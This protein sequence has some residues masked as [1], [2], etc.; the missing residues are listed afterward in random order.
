L[1]LNPVSKIQEAQADTPFSLSLAYFIST[2]KVCFQTI[3]ATQ[4]K[5][6]S[7]QNKTKQIPPNQIISVYGR[8]LAGILQVGVAL[9]GSFA[10]LEG[11][12]S[13]NELPCLALI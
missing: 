2:H 1:L 10:C 11:F 5:L 12:L 6:V 13:S 7:R 4:T 3:R 8:A 9:H